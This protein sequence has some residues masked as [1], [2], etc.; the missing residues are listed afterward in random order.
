MPQAI[1][2]LTTP[3]N[4]NQKRK[5]VLQKV[6]SQRIEVTPCGKY[7][8]LLLPDDPTSELNGHIIEREIRDCQPVWL[9]IEK[10]HAP[11]LARDRRWSYGACSEVAA[12][13]ALYL[14]PDSCSGAGKN[15]SSRTSPA[16]SQAIAPF[17][18]QASA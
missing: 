14:F 17:F 2:D 15:K 10:T 11:Q 12:A 16:T 18:A 13:W 4:A 9:A 1:A 3:S 8:L 5:T 7:K 6:S